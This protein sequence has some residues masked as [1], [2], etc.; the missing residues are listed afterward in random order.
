MHRLLLTLALFFS[1]QKISFAQDTLPKITVT[2][3]GKKVLI[4]WTNPYTTAT[5]INIQRSADSMKNFKTI[6]SV[7]N[8]NANTNGFADT[9]EFIPSQYY[10]LFISFEGGTYLFTQSQKPVLDTSK[11]E[12]LEKVQEKVIPVPVPVQTWFIPSK[13]VY[14]GKD[15]NVI[16]SLP[17]AEHKKY[18]IKFY[19]ENGT[20]LFELKNIPESFLT[21]DKVNFIHSGLFDFELYDNRIIIE[22]HKFYIPKDGQPMPVLDVN[23]H[24][25]N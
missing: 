20:F 11:S 17:D 1:L 9:K 25:I 14:T 23:G 10:R 18:S 6:G 19:E 5:N 3:L 12:V 16:I 24:E 15:N 2:Q 4:S 22:K 21:L 8:V 7:L 13:H